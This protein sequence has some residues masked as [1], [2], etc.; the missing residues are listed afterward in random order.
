M[1]LTQEQQEIVSTDLAKGQSLCV[2][3]G[4]GTGKTTC[5]VEFCK[6]RPTQNFLYLCFNNKAAKEAQEKYKASLVTNTKTSTIHGLASKMRTKYENANKF[7]PKLSIKDI[8]KAFGYSPKLSWLVL[9]TIKNFCFSNENT[10]TLLHLPDI[11]DQRSKSAPILVKESTKVW[12][13]MISLKT[14]TPISYDHYLKVFALSNPKLNFDYILLDEAQDSNPLTLAL[15]KSQEQNTRTVLI[16][17]QNQ[18]IYGWRG[19]KNAMQSWNPTLK[20]KLTE[21]FRFGEK[22][23]SVANKLLSSYPLLPNPQTPNAQTD[24]NPRIVGSKKADNVLGARKSTPENLTYIS[25]TNATLFE[26]A[27]ELQEQGFKCHFIG[28]EESSNWNPTIAYKLNDLKDVYWLWCGDKTKIQSP[29]IKTFQNYHEMR[30]TAIVEDIKKPKEI[31]WSQGFKKIQGDKELEFL[32]KMVEKYKHNLPQIL[33]TIKSQACGPA[34]KPE[35]KVITLCTA[36]RAKG[37]EWDKVEISNDYICIEEKKPEDVDD[38][39][40]YIKSTN[41]KDYD[42]KLESQIEEINL[43][44]VACTRAKKELI[45]NDNLTQ[46]CPTI[47]LKNITETKEPSD[48]S[49]KIPKQISNNDNLYLTM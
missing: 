34:K 19:A 11:I 10:I 43:L 27:I 32:C 1:K 8:E 28:T 40:E 44:Y 42:P 5:F 26:K 14:T 12:N 49:K 46:L 25:R 15:L 9:E 41:Y 4:A 45:L 37:L 3:A 23:A 2:E 38:N 29:Y 30:K 47:E 13:K 7:R 33:H 16:G 6:A 21:S 18:A 48:I 35:D 17:D 20:L 22:I 31:H 24:H 39:Q 36:H